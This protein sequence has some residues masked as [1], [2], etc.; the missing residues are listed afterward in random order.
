MQIQ[1]CQGKKTKKHKTGSISSGL[2]KIVLHADN[3]TNRV[4]YLYIELVRISPETKIS[5]IDLT[6]QPPVN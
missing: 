3:K 5:G 1:M 2:T 6:K 4:N